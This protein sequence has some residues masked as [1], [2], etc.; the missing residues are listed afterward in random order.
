[1]TANLNSTNNH[2][3]SQLAT[4]VLIRGFIL[5]CLWLALGY[6]VWHRELSLSLAWVLPNLLGLSLFNLLTYW[7]IQRELEITAAE[8]F[9]QLIIDIIA[10]SL[11]FYGSGGASNP[12]ISY[13][14]VP[15]CVAAASLPGRFALAISLCSLV[16]YS[17][18]LFFYIPLPLLAPD[19]HSNYQQLNAHVLGMWF[20][21]FISTGL[22]TYFVVKMAR[23]LAARDALLQRK[24]EDEL[25]NEQLIAVATLA[26]G[27]AHELG[28][29][30]STIK[31]MLGEISAAY[32]Q[33]SDLQ[34]DLALLKSQTELCSSTLRRLVNTAE[35]HKDGMQEAVE[36][37]AFC[38][39]V[40]D[41]WQL[42]RPDASFK[43]HINP[44]APQQHCRFHLSISQALINLL[45][46]AANASPVDIQ[47]EISWNQEELIWKI[48]DQGLGIAP[49]LLNKLGKQRMPNS[50]QGLG[51]GMMISQASIDRFGGKL[52]LSN[53][54]PVD[55]IQGTITQIHLPLK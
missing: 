44:T 8:F 54:L 20:N 48:L 36:L 27:T 26:A 39:S 18:L 12:F 55:G 21:F 29:P 6:F 40:L 7:R 19:H 10:L 41:H 5:V 32:P 50:E 3:P 37:R 38:L 42:L 23:D 33:D 45:N 49:E 22:I 16:S 15:I 4:W 53:R 13:F 30:L 43:L 47:I 28:T 1:M 25:R 2:Y 34:D 9:T 24:R 31:L 11:I 17:L 52:N 35:Q 51:V 46:N 14:L